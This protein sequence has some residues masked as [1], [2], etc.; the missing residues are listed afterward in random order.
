MIYLI[1]VLENMYSIDNYTSGVLLTEGLLLL[2]VFFV[3]YRTVRDIHSGACLH[4][5]CPVSRQLSMDG[6][7]LR[8]ESVGVKVGSV[9]FVFTFSVRF[10]P[11]LTY[12]S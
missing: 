1:M 10:S 12:T 5:I 6:T 7:W 8:D 2:S 9:H 4:G 11:R 3:S